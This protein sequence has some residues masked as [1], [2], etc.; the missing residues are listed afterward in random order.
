MTKYDETLKV[1]EI[2]DDL[3]TLAYC[4]DKAELYNDDLLK[5]GEVS[6][7]CFEHLCEQGLIQLQDLPDRTGIHWY[8]LSLRGL[9]ALKESKE[10]L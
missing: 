3:H 8:E 10:N 9:N 5:S 6:A 2:L 7:E 1:L 4:N